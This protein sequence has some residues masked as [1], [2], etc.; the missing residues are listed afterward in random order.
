MKIRGYVSILAEVALIAAVIGSIAAGGCTFGTDENADEQLPIASVTKIM[1]MLL[2]A[3]AVDNGKITLEDMVPVSEN[4]MSYGGSTMF[5]EADEK[6][7][8]QYVSRIEKSEAETV[9]KMLKTKTLKELI[10]LIAQNMI[11]QSQKEENQESIR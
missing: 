11:A 3:E 4:A 7:L 9:Q 6:I 8:K 1:T 2:I 5:L 10:T